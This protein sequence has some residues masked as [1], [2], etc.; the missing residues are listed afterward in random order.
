[1]VFSHMVS[2]LW[3]HQLPDALL[4][5]SSS[6]SA[7]HLIKDLS[8]SGWR[9]RS[10]QQTLWV[11]WMLSLDTGG[12]SCQAED[13]DHGK[14]RDIT[15]MGAWWGQWAVSCLLAPGLAFLVG[16]PTARPDKAA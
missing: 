2:S 9:L 7:C 16:G 5:T 14:N 10:Y 3:T 11:P 6:L 8:G 1:M 4:I 12:V 13:T 15:G